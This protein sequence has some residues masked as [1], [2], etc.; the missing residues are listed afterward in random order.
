MF[1]GGSCRPDNTSSHRFTCACPPGYS[2]TKCTIPVNTCTTITCQNGGKCILR[3]DQSRPMCECPSGYTGDTCESTWDPCTGIMCLNAGM[4]KIA[5]SGNGFL[6]VCP[7]QFY[8]E[9]CELERQP[10]A[11]SPC[12]NGGVC[13]NVFP[14]FRCQ[15]RKGYT[16]KYCERRQTVESTT[17]YVNR[18]VTI[19]TH[20]NGNDM[21]SSTG[22]ISVHARTYHYQNVFVSLFFT[23]VLNCFI[24]VSERK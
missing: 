22:A 14:N 2:G 11:D 19:T 8:G 17:L 5:P 13:E 1:S 10:C 16:G 9:M 7:K 6:C 20:R 21:L 23:C 12:I 24:N 4:C 3:L 15:C 18:K